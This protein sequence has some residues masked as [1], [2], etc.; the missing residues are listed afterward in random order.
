MVIGAEQHK[1][2]LWAQQAIER[3]KHDNRA[4]TPNNYSLF[5][6]YYSGENPNLNMAMDLLLSQ[7]G[8]LTQQQCDD[9]FR[10]H[11]GLGAEHKILQ[12]ANNAIEGEINRVLG[13]IDASVSDTS[14]YGKTLDNFSGKLATSSSLDQIREAVTKVVNETRVMSQQNERLQRELAQATEQLTETRYNLDIIHKESQVDPLTEVGNRKFLDREMARV[15]R[16][17]VEGDTPLALL[18]V[19][20]DHFKKFNDNYGHQIG[21]QVLRLVAKTLVENLK[22]QD[23]IARYGGEEF[24]ILLPQTTV[25]DAEKLA[26]SLRAR[27]STK[28]LKRRSTN[29]TLGAITVSIGAAQLC[30]GEDKDSIISRADTALYKAKQAGRNRVALSIPTP[31]ELESIKNAAAE[32]KKSA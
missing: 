16:E 32:N 7:H 24:C 21:D 15:M 10:T 8:G 27:L 28:Q 20:I 4:P 30:P 29:E 14:E 31:E 26:N 25:S 1:A 18:M 5:Y 3:L 9:L 2:E 12:D 11:L 13:M 22:G 19:D 17:S 23:I 6:N